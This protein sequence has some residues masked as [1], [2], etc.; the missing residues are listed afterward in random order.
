MTR[1]LE[2]SVIS[3][4]LSYLNEDDILSL[5][6]TRTASWTKAA[7]LTI[8]TFIRKL[9]PILCLLFHYSTQESAPIPALKGGNPDP[10]A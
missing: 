5:M 4:I 6:V 1:T 9:G 3:R 2:A 7:R 8:S 10:D